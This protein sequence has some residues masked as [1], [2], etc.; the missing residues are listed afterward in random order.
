MNDY[1]LT[2]L[3]RERHRQLLSEV[4]PSHGQLVRH[5]PGY[6]ERWTAIGALIRTQLLT[7]CLIG[8][9]TAGGRGKKR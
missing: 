8:G 5:V 3:T 4:R 1:F 9:I 7:W 6:I 2:I